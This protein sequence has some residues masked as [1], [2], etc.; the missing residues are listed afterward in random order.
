MTLNDLLNDAAA[1]AE[2]MDRLGE[3]TGMRP[4]TVLMISTP[5]VTAWTPFEEMM[6]HGTGTSP[7]PKHP[8][9][10]AGFTWESLARLAV[11]SEKETL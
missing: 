8:N 9:V 5:R 1:E 4:Q 3:L 6:A 2:L 11:A 7:F 10:G